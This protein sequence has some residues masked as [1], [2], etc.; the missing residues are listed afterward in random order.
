MRRSP[1]SG[2]DHRM[3]VFA[4]TTKIEGSSTLDLTPRSAWR[5]A[6]AQ[7]HLQLLREAKRIVLYL[8]WYSYAALLHYLIS[9]EQYC[10]VRCGSSSPF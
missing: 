9:F 3:C 4:S 8:V 7:E 6:S 1:R 5:A 2:S 10:T